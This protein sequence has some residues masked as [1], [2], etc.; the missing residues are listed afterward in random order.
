MMYPLIRNY[1]IHH[2]L[3]TQQA[4]TPYLFEAPDRRECMASET[5]PAAVRWPD[6]SNPLDAALAYH[7]AGLCVIPLN[8]K[9]PALGGWKPYQR[10]RPAKAD[11]RRWAA[12]GLLQNVG[13]VCGA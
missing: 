1:R 10:E 12:E 8:G 5:P 2:S 7:H 6:T 4:Q 13:I 9:R 11:I 3:P